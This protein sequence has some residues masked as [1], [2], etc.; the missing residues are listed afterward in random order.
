LYSHEYPGG[1][2]LKLKYPAG[3]HNTSVALDMRLWAAI[4]K[5]NEISPSFSLSIEVE[6]T[7]RNTLSEYVE[8]RGLKIPDDPFTFLIEMYDERIAMIQAE[9]ATIIALREKNSKLRSKSMA[10]A[11]SGK[12]VEVRDLGS[13]DIKTI[14][15][16]LYNSAVPGTYKK[17]KELS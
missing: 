8:D 4:R 14:S 2:I 5:I 1:S 13:G 3:I 16:S 6:K 15:L 17:L 10:G 7:V 12:S 9:K 11:G